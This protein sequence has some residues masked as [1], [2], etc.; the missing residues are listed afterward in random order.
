[1]TWAT[2]GLEIILEKPSEG[3]QIYPL[4]PSGFC[5]PFPEYCL[6]PKPRRNGGDRLGEAQRAGSRP[7]RRRQ[8]LLLRAPPRSA[9]SSSGSPAPSSP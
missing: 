9:G 6:R 2:R 7:R 8:L 4:H 1:M 3:E 5:S